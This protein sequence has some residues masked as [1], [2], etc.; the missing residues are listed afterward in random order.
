MSRL[1]F[2]LPIESD[3]TPE[4]LPSESDDLINQYLE[5][6]DTND[7]VE[8]LMVEPNDD[9]D[10]MVLRCMN[11]I[12]KGRLFM[13]ENVEYG[14][15]RLTRMIV[16]NVDGIPLVLVTYHTDPGRYYLFTYLKNYSVYQGTSRLV[17]E[18]CEDIGLIHNGFP[19]SLDQLSTIVTRFTTYGV[20][21]TQSELKIASHRVGFYQD[22]TRFN[23]EQSQN[24]QTADTATYDRGP[25]R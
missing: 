19:L 4:V 23:R 21:L 22:L 10:F 25:Y 18:V 14:L 8:G 24:I 7:L 16:I 11:R 17:Q 2:S 20:K 9:I 3:L 15:Y 12:A 5:L 13:F 6:S 1:R